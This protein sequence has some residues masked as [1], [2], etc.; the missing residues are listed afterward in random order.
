MQDDSQNE[1]LRTPI[2]ENQVFCLVSRCARCG[3]LI[4]AKSVYELVDLEEQH[5]L[6]CKVRGCIRLE[7]GSA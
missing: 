5:V 7:I 4:L 3:D 6:E 2:L 1:F